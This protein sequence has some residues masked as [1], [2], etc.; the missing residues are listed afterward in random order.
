MCDAT[1]KIRYNKIKIK[2]LDGFSRR[3][4]SVCMFYTAPLKYALH[5]LVR[6]EIIWMICFVNEKIYL[7]CST[8]R[9]SM[10]V[11]I[12]FTIKPSTHKHTYVC[13]K[14]KS[15]KINHNHS[16][17]SFSHRFYVAGFQLY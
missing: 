11:H 6:I 9:K 12:L 4:V 17:T 10:Y 14:K 15:L 16:F 1:T 5:K 13:V 8:P 2:S 3:Y 7:L